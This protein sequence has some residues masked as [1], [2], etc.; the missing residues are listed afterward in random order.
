MRLGNSADTS[1]STQ[2]GGG[3]SGYDVSREQQEVN[4]EQE[5][6]HH[7]RN[8]EHLHPERTENPQPDVNP[9]RETPMTPNPGKEPGK[10]P[11]Q[12]QTNPDN[13]AK[14]SFNRNVMSGWSQSSW[15]ANSFR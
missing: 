8:E 1:G 2:K 14:A 3:G 9:G 11:E 7:E 6:M 12:P 5:I 15:D 4:K 13:G 10:E